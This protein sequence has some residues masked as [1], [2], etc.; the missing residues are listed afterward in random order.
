[1]DIIKDLVLTNRTV[2]K[3]TLMVYKSNLLLFLLAI[4][5]MAITLS[6]G[7]LA[8]ML[9]FFGGILIFVVQAGVVS[10]Y[11]H[12]I[13]QVITRRKF[14]VEDFKNGFTIHFR[15]VYMVLFVLWVAN[16]GISLLLMPI[17]NA[18]N[19]GFVLY[20]FYI[21][22]FLILNP[23]PEMIYQRHYSEP[24]T[25]M[26]SVEFSRENVISWFVPNSV[27]IVALLAV[28]GLINGLL[29]PVGSSLLILLVMSVVSAGLI[30]FGMIYRGY[31]FDILYKTTRRKR[32]FSETMYRN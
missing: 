8:S 18:M 25:L 14:D 24:E 31:L 7:T 16:Y 30:S 3:K 12:I 2:L 15:K 4:P 11:L 23:L 19:L 27:L 21:F 9:G 26:K 17:L 5:Y 22:V 29:A 28:R 20:A 32:L 1:M 13:H 6:A 10:D